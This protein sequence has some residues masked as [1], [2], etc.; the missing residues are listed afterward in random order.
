MDQD[1]RMGATRLVLS[2]LSPTHDFQ[3][4][5][6]LTMLFFSPISVRKILHFCVCKIMFSVVKSGEYFFNIYDKKINI[7]SEP[8]NLW[9]LKK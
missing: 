9:S 1:G 2:T 5:L 8:Q 7:G 6:P 4:L 3:V